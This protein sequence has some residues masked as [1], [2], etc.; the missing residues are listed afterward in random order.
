MDES[1]PAHAT[2]DATPSPFRRFPWAA[3][4]FCVACL[5][6]T[7]WTW[8]RYSYAWELP[9]KGLGS[10]V[11]HSS[12]DGVD[13]WRPAFI[14]PSA[15]PAGSFVRLTVTSEGLALF[16]EPLYVTNAWT[17]NPVWPHADGKGWHVSRSSGEKPQARRLHGRLTPYRPRLPMGSAA[18][19]CIADGTPVV[20]TT[21]SRFHPAS[22]AGLVVG[23]MGVFVFGLYLRRWLDERR[24]VS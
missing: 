15:W 17:E 23:A 11:G 3:L 16:A 10:F 12:N 24:A 19:D 14:D 13:V 6:M 7:T 5:T 22:I 4:A 9:P 20:D 1:A 2:D 21:A 18:P 8:M